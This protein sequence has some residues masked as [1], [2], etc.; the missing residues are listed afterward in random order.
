[1]TRLHLTRRAL[2]DLAEIKTYSIEQYGQSVADHY[3]HDLQES[4][5]IICAYPDLLK[6]KPFAKHTRFFTV[7]KHVLVFAVLGHDL[8]LLTV[9]HGGMDI[10]TLIARLEP[11]L[12]HEAQILHGKLKNAHVSI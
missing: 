3:M 4:F 1:M 5:K 10:E 9:R 2:A 7:R 12:I 11:T 8:Y 6:D